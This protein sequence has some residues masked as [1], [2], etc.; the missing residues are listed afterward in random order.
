MSHS[1]F[2]PAIAQPVSFNDSGIYT[3]YGY[4]QERSHATP[5]YWWQPVHVVGTE[6]APPPFV[7]GIVFPNYT[8]TGSPV[9]DLFK[10]LHRSR[11][12]SGNPFIDGLIG[13]EPNPGPTIKPPR[14]KGRAQSMGGKRNLSNRGLVTTFSRSSSS[15]VS[16]PM[17]TG[18]TYRGNGIKGIVSKGTQ[19]VLGSPA[20]I[21]VG[22]CAFQNLVSNGGG[23]A[24]FQDGGV[25]QANIAYIN[26]RICCQNA[27]YNVPAGFCPIG[28]IAQPY[29][30]FS[31]RK[32]KIH[33]RP[34]AATTSNSGVI[35]F[36]YD[37]EV[38]VTTGLNSV[39]AYAN[40]E[41]SV[42]GPMWSNLTL[43]LTPYIDKSR[44]FYGETPAT[45][46]TSLIASQAIQGSLMLYGST[47]PA[48]NTAYGMFF[49]EFELALSELG[50]TEVF[51][52]PAIGASS[53]SVVPVNSG[54]NSED[55]NK[56]KCEEKSSDKT[57]IIVHEEYIVVDGERKLIQSSSLK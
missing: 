32:L 41:A 28:V 24:V 19:M 3:R 39:M 46:G 11:P 30:R 1:A 2:N 23:T 34:T 47:L 40:F 45:I 35:A 22:H 44:W 9:V 38:I 26:P 48:A 21:M 29:R 37:P 6:D 5:K 49:M 36:A 14:S 18:T 8:G 56:C 15:S 16:A 53:T 10:P 7:D 42:Y 33:Y 12:R 25:T 31:F 13:I 17:S 43:D 20:H 50:P 52:V 4:E 55:T 54:A 51:T 57:S 27:V